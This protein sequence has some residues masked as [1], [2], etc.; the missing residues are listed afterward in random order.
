MRFSLLIPAAL[1]GMSLQY[2]TIAQTTTVAYSADYIIETAAGAM[3]GR[4]YATPGMERRED[5]TPDGSTMV[6]IRRDEDQS[7]VMLMPAERMYIEMNLGQMAEGA[8]A[9][10]R[11][12]SPEEYQTEMTT[13]GR[14]EVA[15]VMT[16]KSKVIM[17][18]ADGS[19]MGGFWWTSDDGVVIKMDVISVAEGD[20]VRMK[21]ELSNVEV[22]PQPAELFEIPEGYTSMAGAIGAGFL[23]GAFGGASSS[24]DSGAP[25]ATEEAAEG[26]EPKRR[27][28][29]SALRGVLG[30]R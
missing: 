8:G 14:E 20:K 22:G 25:A 7:I 26:G 18:G 10:S 30:G 5:L 4:I 29:G 6:S 9:V 16:T 27:G 17:T 11:T 2:A 24:G 21:R 15:G 1:V 28:F 3:R 13:E 23:G 19:K 12:P